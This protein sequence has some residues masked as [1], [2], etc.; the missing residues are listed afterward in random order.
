MPLGN[1]R[2][3]SIPR[4]ES[5]RE[6]EYQD[7][8]RGEIVQRQ[9]GTP[10]CR[11]C[12]VRSVRLYLGSSLTTQATDSYENTIAQ[13]EELILET[14]CYDLPIP[15]PLGY[16]LRAH[17][18]LYPLPPDLQDPGVE[19]GKEKE[20]EK[21]PSVWG[22]DENT[23][24][25]NRPRTQRNRELQEKLEQYQEQQKR[26]ADLKQRRRKAQETMRGEELERAAVLDMAY[27]ICDET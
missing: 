22:E 24:G 14:L 2:G 19:K 8:S 1:R 21:K 23:Y 7:P 26:M 27:V 12:F 10:Q 13:Y 6:D 16:I 18:F 3:L 9:T 11:E 17:S 5:G 15:Q 25:L 4:A 20:K